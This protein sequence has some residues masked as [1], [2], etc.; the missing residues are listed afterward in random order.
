LAR[1]VVGLMMLGST[2]V[3]RKAGMRHNVLSQG[4]HFSILALRYCAKRFS[5]TLCLGG[6]T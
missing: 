2:A 5:L 4:R 6:R 3:E 1:F